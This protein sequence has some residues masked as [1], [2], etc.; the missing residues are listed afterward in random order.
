MMQQKL[1]NLYQQIDSCRFCKKSKNYLQHIHG[2]GAAR[3]KFML[4]LINPTHR[5]LT[6]D[7]TYQGARFPFVG[8]RQF[9]QVLA[10]GG[11]TSQTIADQLPKR[12][13]WKILHTQILQQELL[14]KRLFITNVVKCCYN[15]S[16]YPAKVVIA[17]Q[18][19]YLRQEIQIVRLRKIIAFG[20]LVY[21]ILT[22][23]NII[24][25]NYW[26]NYPL[27]KTDK[28]II[29]G[30]NIPTVPVYFPV[31]RGNP[32]KA[33]QVIHKIQKIKGCETH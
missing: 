3:P 27:K 2:F 26:Q 21:K 17:H 8:V 5:N 23:Q 33:I 11:F 14:Q 18:I 15:H 25:K 20:A 32:A 1:K 30:L 13:S 12:S 24:L 29:S 19:N 4:I 10:K 22:S 9:W 7:P 31:G 16:N 28:E 6:A